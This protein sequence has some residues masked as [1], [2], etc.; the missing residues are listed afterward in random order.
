MTGID[1]WDDNEQEKTSTGKSPA[2]MGSNN[3]QGASGSG[4]SPKKSLWQSTTGKKQK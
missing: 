4:S 2:L 1:D 3:D